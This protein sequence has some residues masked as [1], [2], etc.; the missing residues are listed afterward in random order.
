MIKFDGMKAE[1]QVSGYPM[2]P[3]GPYVGKILNVKI[4]GD[5]PNQVLVLRLDVTEGEHKDYFTNRYNSEKNAGGKFEAKYRGDLK[6]HIP[7]PNSSRQWPETDKRRLN[8]ALYRVEQSNPG[9]HFDGDERTLVGKT[10]GFSMQ[11]GLYN[12][13]PYTNIARL[14]TADDVRKGLVSRMKDK[15]PGYSPDYQAQQAAPATSGF[16]PVED[17]EIEIPF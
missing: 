4:D 2:L 11:E 14:E 13:K 8:D 17:S 5:A 1:A 12:D 10:V 7:H 15:K 3:A 6:L 9:Y 16:T